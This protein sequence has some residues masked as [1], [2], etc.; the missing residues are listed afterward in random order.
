LALFL[1]AFFIGILVAATGYGTWYA[2]FPL[3]A[4][5]ICALPYTIHF[6]VFSWRLGILIRAINTQETTFRTTLMRHLPAGP[7]LLDESALIRIVGIMD[8]TLVLSMPIVVAGTGDMTADGTWTLPLP[9]DE[10]ALLEIGREVF[11]SI[12]KVKLIGHN[13]DT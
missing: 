10:K 7:R 8:N 2:N 13:W 6:L 11:G 4:V 9:I 12:E 5:A 3:K 1:L